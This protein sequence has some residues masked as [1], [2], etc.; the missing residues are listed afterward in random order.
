MAKPEEK[1]V[2]QKRFF[3]KIRG[4]KRFLLFSG[5]YLGLFLVLLAG[6]AEYTSRPSFC[7]TCHYMESFYN[8]WK[9]SAHNKVDCVECHFE[10]GI[11]GT[12]K[13]KANGLVQI[14]NYVT[15]SY[16]KRKP[17]AE[18]PDNTCNRVGCHETQQFKDSVYDFEGVAFSHKHHLED[19]RRG[20]KLKCISC[21]SQIVQGTHMEVTGST[22]FNCHFKKSD[23]P[24]H[25]YD[26][27][28]QCNTC[29]AFDKKP[30]E[31]LASLRYNHV[32]VVEKKYSCE[33]CHSAVVQ[34]KGEVGKERCFQC[35][36]ETERLEKYDDVEYM[37]TTHIA[38]HTLK[39]FECHTPINHKIQP[40]DPGADP[41]CASCHSN[42]HNAQVSLFSGENG[43]NVEKSPSAMF[44]NGM[45][46]KGCHIFHEIDK[47]DLGTSK[48]GG[49]ACESCHG[50]GYD[51]IV[52]EWEKTATERLK[53][54]KSIYNVSEQNVR[55]SS[56]PKKAD[57]EKKL[58]E[59]QHNIRLVEV[60]KAVHNVQFADKL[61]VGA[62]SLMK[63]AL[64]V[65]GSSASLPSF[66]SNSEVI[67][68]ECYRC[69][70]GIQE[71]NVK[72]FDMTFSHNMHI[73]NQKI[74]CDRCH[75][76]ANKHGETTITK[77]GCNNCHHSKAKDS[78]D[79]CNKCHQFQNQV[80][81]G[82][83]FGKN[84]PDIM[85][86]GG[87]KCI[88]CHVDEGKVIKPDSKVCL[89]CHDSGYDEMMDE[90]KSDV[91][92][93][94]AEVNELINSINRNELND[95]QRADLDE[96]KK[97]VSKISSY[98]SIYVHNNEM[99]NTVLSDGKKKLKAM[100]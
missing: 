84:T 100:K 33:G 3:N 25:K 97:N 6:A 63:E 8:S 91:K 61:L 26:K 30:K 49:S 20:K 82:A 96:V 89:K 14:V 9:T 66:V 1:P 55:G 10:P 80:Y 77:D 2:R 4:W 95:Q 13:G 44:S 35:H 67:P 74:A 72:K 69:H 41:D 37:H 71:I 94:T 5:I 24:E 88:D 19:F 27:L 54:I 73:L 47:N 90:W 42:A 31:V 12:I 23:D 87:S 40:M 18:I 11:S 29:H 45:N 78:D 39:C 83:A 75:S 43:F 46:C 48:S 99:I 70:S 15:M 62:Y 79:A 57:A 81:S 21:H 93:L 50:E 34:G 68:N 22:C 52:K 56:S 92:K 59:A 51:R 64:T 58:G 60:G 32:N 17:W 7:P 86:E 28:S 38:K 65:V 36:F 16:K 53:I 85:K 98:P 76:N